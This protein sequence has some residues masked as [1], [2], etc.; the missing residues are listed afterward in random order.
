MSR[1]PFGQPSAAT[2]AADLA[3]FA[4]PNPECALVNRFAVGNL[5][6]S[7]WIDQRHA[8]R[9]LYCDQC[10]P[11]FS[12][13][14]G[15][16]LQDTKLPRV[17][18]VRLLKCLM[19][20]CSLEAAADICDVDPRTVERLLEAAGRRAEDFHRLQLG[21]LTQPPEV[22]QLDELHARVAGAAPEKRGA[23]G[24]GGGPRRDRI[25]AWGAP[26]SLS[27]WP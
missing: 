12:E 17:A 3:R 5:C 18:V 27:P 9:R 1:Q 23:R 11:R 2:R 25:A 16:L 7:G 19:H 4:C 15:T 20:G 13:H 6:V 21:R 14:H 10:G 26:G 22:V 8:V 24:P